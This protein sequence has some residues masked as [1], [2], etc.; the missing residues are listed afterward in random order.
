[1][2]R[3][4][5]ILTVI[6][7]AL[8][9]SSCAEETR[10]DTVG[11]VPLSEAISTETSAETLSE[12]ETAEASETT[13]IS[14]TSV[15]EKLSGLSVAEVGIIGHI[16]EFDDVVPCKF[17]LGEAVEPDPTVLETAV[18]AYRQTD[19]YKNALEMMREYY[20]YNDSGEL[21]ESEEMYFLPRYAKEMLMESAA[22]E[23]DIDAAAVYSYNVG[24]GQLIVLMAVLPDSLF[25]WSGTGIAHIPVYV[26]GSGEAFVLD[27]A[28]SQDYSGCFTV[29]YE[30]GSIHAVMN[31]GHNM[32]GMQS[33]VYSFEGGVPKPEISGW[34]HIDIEEGMPVLF[35]YN[36][37]YMNELFF[38]RE[39]SPGY[40]L[41][42]GVNADEE[43]ARAICSDETVLERVPNA[44]ELYQG[45]NL[46]VYG[47][48][49]IE[50]T[51]GFAP[52]FSI[53]PQ[54]GKVTPD[55]SVI[56]FMHDEFPGDF[57]RFNIDLT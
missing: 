39:N 23:V 14:E 41:V 22:P 15:T 48:K 56:D 3:Q 36:S 17:T 37:F 19:Y 43:L 55:K 4:K 10:N 25:V 9:A 28:C 40:C 26:N 54:T 1:M 18:N 49:Y 27:E 45:G 31:F 21:V 42:K 46:N 47:G 2:K 7:T 20:S 34:G 44:R 6:L 53:D 16:D 11:E 52:T 12:S 5:L 33:A 13:Q 29:E 51:D 8:I 38:R 32:G 35:A 24:D 30:D 50:I 57:E